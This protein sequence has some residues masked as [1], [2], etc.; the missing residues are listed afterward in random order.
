MYLK[1]TNTEELNLIDFRSQTT[2]DTLTYSVITEKIIIQIRPSHSV[3]LIQS[4]ILRNLK[5]MRPHIS[6]L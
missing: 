2:E 3:L 6:P 1:I 5:F 4:I